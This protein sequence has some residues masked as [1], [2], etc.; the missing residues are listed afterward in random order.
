V[1]KKI[2]EKIPLE[3]VMGCG[4]GTLASARR[5]YGF[6]QKFFTHARKPLRLINPPGGKKMFLKIIPPNIH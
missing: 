2:L 3:P 6:F 1:G 5:G 4:G